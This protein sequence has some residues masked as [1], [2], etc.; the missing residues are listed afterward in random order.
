MATRNFGASAASDL[1][2]PLGASVSA[3]DDVDRQSVDNV[4][5]LRPRTPAHPRQTERQNRQT[6]RL[7]VVI[8]EVLREE[9]HRQQRTLVDVADRAAVSVPYL[10][11]VERGRKEV[12][13]D[14]LDAVVRALDVELADVLE[15]SA[16]R[17][18]PEG[19]RRTTMRL[20]AA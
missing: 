9:R 3:M 4:V 2:S 16:R 15:R 1:V 5:P 6:E 8:G 11:E 12:S 10:S 14:V 20:L 17:L 19:T 13:S 7:R 18:R